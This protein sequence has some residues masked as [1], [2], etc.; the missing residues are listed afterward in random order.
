MKGQSK[1]EAAVLYN[2]VGLTSKASEEIT[3]K[4]ALFSTFAAKVLK[5]AVFDNP[6]V[7]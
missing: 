2:N 7:V 4:T 1:G 6:T 5:S 3:S